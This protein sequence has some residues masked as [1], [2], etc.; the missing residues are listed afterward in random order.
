[1][2]FIVFVELDDRKMRYGVVLTGV[3]GFPTIDYVSME[4][5]LIITK[6]TLGVILVRSYFIAT[7]TTSG[8]S[9]SLYFFSTTATKSSLTLDAS[10]LRSHL[11]V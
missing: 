11:S 5:S 4:S 2:H 6:V 3:L 7:F 1:M 10:V 9:V 8:S